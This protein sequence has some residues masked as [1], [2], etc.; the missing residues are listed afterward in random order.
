MSDDTT[1]DEGDGN[2]P[3]G[4]F[5]LRLEPELHLTLRK[6]AREERI[7]LNDLCVRRLAFPDPSLPAEA[8]GAVAKALDVLGPALLGVVAFGSWARGEPGVD[9]DLDLLLVPREGVGI[10]RSLYR[11]WDEAP[12]AG[13]GRAVEPH[14]AHLPVPEARIT[15]FW[16]E[17]ALDGLV[18]FDRDLTVSRSLARLRRRIAS[19]EIVR[20][21][22]HGQ[23]YW[24]EVA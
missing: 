22:V 3:S 21:L 12:A 15:G 11:R 23:T 5:V 2:L 1:C 9:S 19:G 10:D 24:V 20:R 8:R 6:T 13:E 4:R 18:L 14:F 17:V 7:S 16:A